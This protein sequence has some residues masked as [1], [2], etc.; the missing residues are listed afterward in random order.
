[1]RNGPLLV[2]DGPRDA[3]LR[4]FFGKHLLRVMP[5]I[6]ERAFAVDSPAARKASHARAPNERGARTLQGTPAS[7]LT[8]CAPLDPV[9]PGAARRRP[10]AR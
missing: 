3:A 1:M 6:L 4:H 2:A 8:R 10:R 7:R 5:P 9:G